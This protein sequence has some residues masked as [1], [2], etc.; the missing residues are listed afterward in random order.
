MA[1]EGDKVGTRVLILPQVPNRETCQNPEP[2]ER[3]QHK[4][5][6]R[7]LLGPH[8]LKTP[9]MLGS[10]RFQCTCANS[11]WKTTHC[12]PL[13]YEPNYAC[14]VLTILP[15][16]LSKGPGNKT[17]FFW[18]TLTNYGP[19]QEKQ[20]SKGRQLIFSHF[21]APILGSRNNSTRGSVSNVTNPCTQGSRENKGTQL[22]PRFSAQATTRLTCPY[23]IDPT[24]LDIS[25]KPRILISLVYPCF[26]FQ[27]NIKNIT[28][29]GKETRSCSTEVRTRV[30]FS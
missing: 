8:N 11:S 15:S 29:Q 2:Q 26:H 21:R 3:F 17:L 9:A 24:L 5:E 20:R 12:F 4:S 18:V 6:S 22:A 10:K 30:P 13:G 7:L 28:K 16:P 1:F 14:W 19:T 25:T 23:Y 27:S